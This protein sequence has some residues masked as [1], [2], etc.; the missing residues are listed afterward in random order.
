[1]TRK[2]HPLKPGEI[3]EGRAEFLPSPRVHAHQRILEPELEPGVTWHLGQVLDLPED[4]GRQRAANV[5]MREEV[6]RPCT[7][8]PP[9]LSDPCGQLCG[10]PWRATGLPEPH[11]SVG[12]H[13]KDGGRRG[14]GELLPRLWR[15]DL[16]P[17]WGDYLLISPGFIIA[18][19]DAEEMNARVIMEFREEA[20]QFRP[21]TSAC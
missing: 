8:L 10:Q 13:D 4:L 18:G 11:D 20:L 2:T 16:E 7:D 6:P 1:M 17:P 19:H 12:T 14:D 21:D 5:G 15:H 9:P 3:P